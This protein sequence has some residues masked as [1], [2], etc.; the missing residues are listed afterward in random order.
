M[1]A[2]GAASQLAAAS[3][4]WESILREAVASSAVG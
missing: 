4:V 2:A 1:T 3:P